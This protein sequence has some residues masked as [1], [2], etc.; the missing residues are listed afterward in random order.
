MLARPAYP[1]DYAE[2]LRILRGRGLTIDQAAA[3]LGISRATA[4][5]LLSRCP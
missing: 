4:Y 2:D 5:R 3:E 1:A